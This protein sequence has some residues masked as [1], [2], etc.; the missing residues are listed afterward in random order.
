MLIRFGLLSFLSKDAIKRAAYFPP[1]IRA[2]KV[3]FAIY[4]LAT[5][6]ILIYMF[7]LKIQTNPSFLFYTGIALYGIGLLLLT[8][9]IVN[10]SAPTNKGIN[11]Q[12]LYRLSRNP[13]YI[14]YFICCAGCAALTRSLILLGFVLIF[15]ISAHWMILAE[16]RWC[17]EQFGPEYLQYMKKTRRYM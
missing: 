6:A 16:E 9:S 17:M 12:G 10:F 1:M 14:A 11:L 2:E 13:M 8:L 5:A 15:Q 7:F 4:Q 3:A